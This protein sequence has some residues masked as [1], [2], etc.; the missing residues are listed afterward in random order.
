MKIGEIIKKYRDEHGYSLREFS[1]ISGVSNSYL[2]M[3][4][5]GRHPRTGRPIVPTLTKINQIAD[6]MGIGVDD[7]INVMDDTPVRFDSDEES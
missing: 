1:R 6:A 5:S 4:E 3:L 7:L 2:S